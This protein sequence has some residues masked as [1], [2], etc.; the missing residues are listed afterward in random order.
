MICENCQRLKAHGETFACMR[1]RAR[2][3]G[4]KCQSCGS[5]WVYLQADGSHYEDGKDRF[6]CKPCTY[7][8]IAEKGLDAAEPVA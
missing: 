7:T 5:P 1:C 6:L 3:E 4:W 8:L 2:E